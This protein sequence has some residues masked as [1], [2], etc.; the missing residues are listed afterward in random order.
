MKISVITVCR[1]AEKTIEET[2]LSALNQTYKNIQYI[3]IDGASTD[4]TLQVVNKYRDKIDV[5]ISEPDK[6]VY[7][8]MNKAI[9]HVTG[10]IVY[11]LN[12]NDLIYDEFMF[13]RMANLFKE[14][15]VDFVFGDCLFMTES[16]EKDQT[17]SCN[18]FKYKAAFCRF[19]MCQQSVFYKADLFKKYGKHDESFKVYA[20]YELNARFLVK[21]DAKM[22]YLPMII[23]K[24]E[25]GGLSSSKEKELNK[26]YVKEMKQ[27]RRRYFKTDFTYSVNQVDTV[28]KKYLGSPYKKALSVFKLDGVIEKLKGEKLNI[29]EYDKSLLKINK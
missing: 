14:T 29:V 22:I 16:R 12:A 27:I 17:Y 6:G 4:N 11:L 13:E 18:R 28:L 19:N 10:D 21:H 7:N 15:D 3:V 25:L 24:F 20:D 5:L 1:N 2:L 9:D 8:A 23:S 26:L